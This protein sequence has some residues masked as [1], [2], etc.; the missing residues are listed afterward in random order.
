[1]K[2]NVLSINNLHTNFD[3]LNSRLELAEFSFIIMIIV[4]PEL[5]SYYYE[6]LE[7]YF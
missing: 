2:G 6:L 4:P 3:T 1:M 5:Q 7:L